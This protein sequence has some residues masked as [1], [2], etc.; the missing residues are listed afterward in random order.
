M[1]S[2]KFS[3]AIL[4]SVI[5]I[6]LTQQFS[7]LYSSRD[8]VM[9]IPNRD[10][11]STELLSRNKFSSSIALENLFDSDPSIKTLEVTFLIIY[12]ISKIIVWSIII[13]NVAA[14]I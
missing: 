14:G 5:V 10:N 7:Q 6:K 8:A 3:P 2:I 1:S 9:P 4:I 12:F 13:S 11:L